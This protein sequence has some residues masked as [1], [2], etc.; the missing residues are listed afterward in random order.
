MYITPTYSLESIF[1]LI[2]EHFGNGAIENICG[3][4][5]ISCEDDPPVTIS[6]RKNDESATLCVYDSS[7]ATVC[8]SNV[9]PVYM[10]TQKANMAIFSEQLMGNPTHLAN[11][12]IT[13]ILDHI[14]D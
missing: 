8:N 7:L 11:K 9:V 14:T 4:E 1:K 10:P 3:S 2:V 13:F 6:F 12:I 5:L